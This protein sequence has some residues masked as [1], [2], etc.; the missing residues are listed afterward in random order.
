MVREAPRTLR[1]LTLAT[2]LAVAIGA[3][4]PQTPVATTGAAT[5]SAPTASPAPSS[6][7]SSSLTA[8]A[9]AEP[10]AA[11]TPVATAA[12]PATPSPTKTPKPTPAPTINTNPVIVAFD[13]PKQ[14]DCTND[15]AGSIHVSWTIKRATGVTISIDGPGIYDTYSGLSGSIDLPFGCDHTVLKHTYTLT[16]MGGTGPAANLTHTVRTRAPSIETFALTPVTGCVDATGSATLR[17][18]YSVRAATGADLYADGA[19]YGSYTDKVAGPIPIAYPC[20]AE[21]IKYKLVTTGG[22]GPAASATI[23]VV[24]PVEP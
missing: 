9:S 7:P 4:S 6:A 20:S 18:S 2:V 3:C 23:T 19:L 10:T 1:V 24:R 15:T 17:L 16:T 21:S 8:E 13:T 5:A 14:E 11:A 12:A 22:Y